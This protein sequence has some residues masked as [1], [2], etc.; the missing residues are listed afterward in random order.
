MGV[1][2]HLVRSAKPNEFGC[3]ARYPVAIKDGPMSLEHKTIV[4]KFEQN[5][6]QRASRA[7]VCP[8][9]EEELRLEETVKIDTSV[10]LSR[11]TP[12]SAVVDLGLQ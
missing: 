10:L 2:I 3:C 5:P 6:T 9:R 7:D 11:R 1:S 4:Q 12:L 8:F